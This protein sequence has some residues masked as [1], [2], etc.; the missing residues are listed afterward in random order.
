M[1]YFECAQVVNG[2]KYNT[3]QIIA[4]VCVLFI[5]PEVLTLYFN[6]C[7]L[8]FK[9]RFGC[10]VIYFGLGFFFGFVLSLNKITMPSA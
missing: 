2:Y 6:V 5:N 3:E 9:L 8:I 10:L 7:E 1:N 4:F